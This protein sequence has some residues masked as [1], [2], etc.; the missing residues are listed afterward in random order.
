MSDPK[1]IKVLIVDDSPFFRQAI[2]KAISIDPQIEIA[3]VAANPSEAR[4][5]IIET[6]PDVITCDV[7]MPIM[8]GIEFLRWLLPQHFVP[9]IMVSSVSDKVFD[10][11]NAGAVDFV[12]KPSGKSPYNAEGFGNDLIHKI[13][14]A[15]G[16]RADTV[17]VRRTAGYIA[18]EKINNSSE[19]IIVMG[20]STGGTEAIFNILKALPP[21]VP[22]IAIVQHIPPVFSKMF[23]ERLNYQT[24]LT[25][26]EAQTGQRLER[27][28]VLIAPG[29]RHMKIKKSGNIFQVECF[30][31]Q[32]INGH[33]PSVD[34][35]FDSSASAA[36]KKTI[37]VLLTGMGYDGAKGLLSIRRK[38]GRTI[39]QDEAS[40]VV[41]GMPKAAHGIGAVERQASLSD[42]PEMIM[43]L[44]SNL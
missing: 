44:L 38:G 40:S 13:K 3:A 21:T 4:D 35:L 8:D 32:K 43:N 7:E 14:A 34:V 24:A 11:M 31:G 12:V 26:N 16:V 37:G 41:Y 15:F 17:K 42:I 36:G 39:G 20:A 33:C 9:V 1:K 29:D 22:G 27:G 5:R 28:T 19:A 23:A 18:G 30:H 10:A 2:A 25:V 6:N